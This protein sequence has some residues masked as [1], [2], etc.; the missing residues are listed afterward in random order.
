MR[1][2]SPAGASPSRAR[3]PSTHP[4]QSR[5]L[6]IFCVISFGPSS[7]DVIS[8]AQPK[9]GTLLKL[10]ADTI[11]PKEPWKP[12]FGTRRQNKGAFPF[13][14]FWA[15]CTGKLRVAFLLELKK[16]SKCFSRPSNENWP[17]D[18][19]ESR[20]RLNRGM[21]SHLSNACGSNFRESV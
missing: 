8:R 6:G 4:K 14:N 5:Q 3:A 13:G 19:N 7:R 16:H 21:T 15:E 20:S 11:W 10:F 12:R 18:T 17:P 9:S 2:A 1:K